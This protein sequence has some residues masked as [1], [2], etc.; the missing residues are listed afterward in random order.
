MYKRLFGWGQSLEKELGNTGRKSGMCA[1]EA[2]GSASP[3]FVPATDWE[4]LAVLQQCS[5]PAKL[6]I[7]YNQA[8]YRKP[9]L[10]PGF[11]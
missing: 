3:S 7:L 6:K 10:S 8:L 11:T 5:L 2:C 9:F 1:L 4:T